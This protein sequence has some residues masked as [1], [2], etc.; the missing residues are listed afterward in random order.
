MPK[1]DEQPSGK[2]RKV[3]HSRKMMVTRETYHC[4]VRAIR[5][6]KLESVTFSSFFSSAT[7][8]FSFSFSFSSLL[9]R[10]AQTRLKKFTN[11]NWRNILMYI[12]IFADRNRKI[13]EIVKTK[14][15]KFLTIINSRRQRDRESRCKNNSRC[16]Y[17]K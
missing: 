16:F 4:Q 6:L 2:K 17:D 13:I 9:T 7:T 14:K 10:T 1:I 11:H 8:V 5:E 15:L 12:V 3:N